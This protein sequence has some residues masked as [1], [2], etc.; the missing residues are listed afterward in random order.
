MPKEVYTIELERPGAVSQEEMAEYIQ[1]A[2][3]GWAGGGDPASPLFGMFT[4][5]PK[6]QVSVSR[7]RSAITATKMHYTGM[8]NL[9]ALVSARLHDE[10]LTDRIERACRDWVEHGAL[11]SGWEV[12]RVGNRVSIQKREEVRG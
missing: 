8:A 6:P 12:V 4:H 5:S 11:T 1:T 3:M 7:Y 9:L 2:V 10:E